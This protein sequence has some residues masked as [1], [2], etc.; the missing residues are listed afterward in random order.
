MRKLPTSFLSPKVLAKLETSVQG[1]FSPS[2][3]LVLK[4]HSKP[5]LS[6]VPIKTSELF[7][8]HQV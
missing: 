3:S 6:L 7:S 1:G 8:L 4:L 2:L 5:S